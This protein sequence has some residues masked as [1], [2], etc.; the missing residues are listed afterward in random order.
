MPTFNT[1]VLNGIAA[2]ISE[3][4]QAQT[5][6]CYYG[7]PISPESMETYA[8]FLAFERPTYSANQSKNRDEA[9]RWINEDNNLGLLVFDL[10]L[11]Y[12]HGITGP[13]SYAGTPNTN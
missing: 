4:Q 10:L 8:Q 1:A 3:L 2:L 5:Q 11:S 12:R 9:A 7:P 13:Y 6:H